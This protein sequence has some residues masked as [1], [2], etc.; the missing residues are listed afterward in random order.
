MRKRFFIFLSLLIAF[1]I[2]LPSY[3]Y[4]STQLTPIN[5]IYKEGIYKISVKDSNS[6]NLQYRLVTPNQECTIFL[7]DENDNIIFRNSK[8]HKQC[9]VGMI[10]NKNTLLIITEGEVFYILKKYKNRFSSSNQY[11]TI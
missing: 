5:S 9:E 2:L 7:L 10:T 11:H 1:T 8:C 4:A 3:S 6:Y